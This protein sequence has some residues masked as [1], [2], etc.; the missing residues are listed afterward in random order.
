MHVHDH[1][2]LPATQLPGIDHRTLAGRRQGLRQL[3]IWRQQLAPGAATP[4]HRHDCEEVVLCHA[5][6][7]TLLI[8][9]RSE[10]FGA[11]S[12]VVLPAGIVHQIRNDG[13]EPLDITGVFAQAP[14]PTR[15]PDGAV[16]ALPW[17]D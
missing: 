1:A 12:T 15:T 11:A 7:G 8:G 16:L 9:D 3:S 13:S 14:V 10:R 17:D 5:G 4:A 6:T 2:T